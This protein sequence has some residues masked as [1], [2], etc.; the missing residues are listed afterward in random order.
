MANVM[1]IWGGLVGP[2]SGNVE[3]VLVFK[4]CLKGSREPRVYLPPRRLVWRFWRFGGVVAWWVHPHTWRPEASV[5]KSSEHLVVR[6]FAWITGKC[7][8]DKTTPTRR[9]KRHVAHVA[10]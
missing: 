10:A 7:Q 5:D 2:K 1:G 9:S 8:N 4:A 6:S 3:K